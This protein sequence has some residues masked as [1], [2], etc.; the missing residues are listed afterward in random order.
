MGTL[1][2]RTVIF[3]GLMC[4]V[5]AGFAQAQTPT[6][7]AVGG[8]GSPPDAMIFYVAHGAAGACGQG[9]SEWMPPKAPFNGIPTSG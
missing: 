5:A 8:I 6:R 4:L 9:C 1:I 2:L 3:G 7:P